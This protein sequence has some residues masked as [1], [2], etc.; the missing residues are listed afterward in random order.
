MIPKNENDIFG[1]VKAPMEGCD[2]GNLPGFMKYFKHRKEHFKELFKVAY[3]DR[4]AVRV[5]N[6]RLRGGM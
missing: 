4:N 3:S 1:G 2:R 6:I 5:F